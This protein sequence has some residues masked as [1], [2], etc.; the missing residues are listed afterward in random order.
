MKQRAY[1]KTTS[2]IVKLRAAF[3]INILDKALASQSP[4][5]NA[6]W[7]SALYDVDKQQ[8]CANGGHDALPKYFQECK[9]V[10]HVSNV[11]REMATACPVT[12]F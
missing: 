5:K 10:G 11:T 8:R 2:K 9:K 12:F 1:R 7:V 3:V 4:S 6:C